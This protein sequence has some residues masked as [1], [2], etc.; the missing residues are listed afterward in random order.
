M[1]RLAL[2]LVIACC[3]PC[4]AAPPP[5]KV[6]VL[7][8]QSN[9]EGQAVVDLSGKNYNEGK[10]TL[11]ERMQDPATAPLL[12][13][14]RGA[15][16]KWTV[17]DDVWVR[18]QREDQPLLS[19]PLS[20]GYA[21][22][23][24]PH[25]F[26]AELQFGH[27]LGNRLEDPVLLIKTAWGG[28]SLYKDFRPPSSG[29][30]TGPYYRKMLEQ[31]QSG[32]TN[33]AAEFPALA[34]RSL[35][36]A[37][38]VWWHGWNDGCE[39]KTAVPEYE[40]NLT[41]LINDVRREWKAPQLPVVIGELTGPWVEAPP[42]WEQLRRA[43][44]AVAQ[45]PEFTGTVAFVPT[46]QF[47]RKAED[48]PNPGHGHHEF[49]NAE[50]YF[51]VGDALGKAMVSLLEKPDKKLPLPGDTF[52]VEGRTAF[53]IPGRTAPEAKA[54][55]WV[56]Y[57][58]TLPGLPGPEE[59]WMFEQFRDAGIA[60]AGIDIGESYGSPDGRALFT[61]LYAELTQRRG[62]SPKPVLLG[63]SRGGLMTLCWAAENADKV[64]GFAGIYPVCNLTS[65]PGLD[66]AAPA[67]NLTPQ[68]LAAKLS[69]HNPVDRLAALAQ[70]KV[71]LFAIHGDVDKVVPLEA[72]SGL[73]KSRYE[74][75]GGSMQL[76]VPPGQGHNMW[77]GFFQC[78]EL[79]AFVKRT[80]KAR[81]VVA[82]YVPVW[83]DL[84]AAA[85]RL[86]FAALTHLHLAFVNPSDAAGTLPFD[87]KVTPL[88]AK[89][90]AAGV[91]VLFSLGGG[92]ASED[93]DMRARYAVLL[94]DGARAGFVKSLASYATA[95]GF[96]GIDVDLEGPAITEQYGAFIRDLAAA[97]KPAGLLMTAALS[98]GYGGDRVPAEA[99]AAFDLVH[100]MAYDATGPWAADRPGQ[101]SSLAFAQ[102]NVQWFL[103]RGLKP[104]RA[105]LGVPFYGYGFGEGMK[106]RSFTY[107]EIVKQWPDAAQRDASGSTVYYNGRAT[108]E[109]KCRYA[110][111]Q[112]LAG[113]MIWTV[114]GDAPGGD[115]LLQTM[116]RILSE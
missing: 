60:V 15:D 89:A 32:L 81:P 33:A 31:V 52:T 45:R 85:E 29:G 72:N 2:A 61:A 23:S 96:D 53:L 9:M 13:H 55:P 36:L 97:L 86:D 90:R 101:H 65:Y 105:V 56:W 83:E 68:E 71:P 14:L 112:N 77:Q 116:H 24:G 11:V 84:A 40:Q 75:L 42:E 35:E 49:G 64:G 94:S 10:G 114:T 76:I 98:K 26:G 109:A 30:E 91:K 1:I 108:I 103:Q 39:P 104:E 110:R 8:G 22:Y 3:L 19:G 73:L 6:F 54:K 34:G 70:A 27:V 102:E 7:A 21:V 43:Q 44:A 51:L 67:H 74:A 4:P 16:G 50:T 12:A 99:L 111:E 79:V 95:H 78:A 25:H 107:A 69:E 47:V 100:I 66:K 59:R 20:V 18:Y 115:S 62:M 106:G 5:V 28:K 113:L 88:M 63:R 58:P 41:N 46:R 17:R 38:F 82:G 80:A 37:G 57:A 48:S 92:G 87:A 93:A